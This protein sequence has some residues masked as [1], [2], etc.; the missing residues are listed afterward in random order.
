MVLPSISKSNTLRR[1]NALRKLTAEEE[2]YRVNIIKWEDII[3]VSN[4]A[5]PLFLLS[6][7]GIRGIIA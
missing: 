3:K 5:N 4:K 1:H 7:D 2:L 6:P